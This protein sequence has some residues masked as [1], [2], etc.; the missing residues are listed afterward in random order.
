MK[1][2]NSAGLQDKAEEVR[3][4]E[5]ALDRTRRALIRMRGEDVEQILSSYQSRMNRTEDEFENPGWMAHRWL[6]DLAD[7]LLTLAK[8]QDVE[9]LG[10][11]PDRALCP[12]CG[13]GAQ[14]PF[15]TGFAVPEGLRRHLLGE[16]NSIQCAV[17]EAALGLAE[18]HA[19]QFWD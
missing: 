1:H 15:S 2:R 9:Q 17:T 7:D 19:D 6:H 5:D 13:R 14:T 4:L 10:Y 8:P 18:E 11:G 3:R 16:G 12:L